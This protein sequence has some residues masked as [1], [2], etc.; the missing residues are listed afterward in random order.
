VGYS[1]RVFADAHARCVRGLNLPEEAIAAARA[2]DESAPTRFVVY[3]VVH[4][5]WL[6]CG[7]FLSFETLEHLPVGRTDDY[8]RQVVGTEE[9]GGVVICSK[10]KRTVRLRGNSPQP[11]MP[12]QFIYIELSRVEPAQ[13]P[14]S[15]FA[16]VE[17]DGLIRT[18]L[19][20]HA[21][22]AA[23]MLASRLVRSPVVPALN[24]RLGY[25]PV[26]LHDGPSLHDLL[27]VVRQPKAETGYEWGDRPRRGT[28]LATA[29]L[30]LRPSPC[31]GT[32]ELDL[33]CWDCAASRSP[34]S[35]FQL[36]S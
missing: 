30:M 22:R 27:P 17:S 11:R 18:G 14:C 33:A 35:A 13:R 29:C 20:H 2:S 15:R 16:P 12:N 7:F 19:F 8:F 26:R 24:E 25:H 3:D 28:N 1:S 4:L 10:P 21:A 23:D 32:N 36:A 31:R 6:R 34:S 9:P 5:L